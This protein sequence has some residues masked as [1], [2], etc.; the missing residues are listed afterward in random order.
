M[1]YQEIYDQ[2]AGYCNCMSEIDPC[3]VEKYLAQ[4]VDYV[5]MMT[6]WKRKSCET[7]LSSEREEV[8]APNYINDCG[9]DQGLTIIPLY[10]THIFEPT[11]Q[12]TIQLRDGVNFC[13]VL[14]DPEDYSFDTY[15]NELYINLS[16]Y[17][18]L[19]G[20][21]CDCTKFKQIIVRY[22]AGYDRIPDCILPIFCDLMSYII[23]L[24][25][26][27]CTQCT[28]CESGSM[29]DEEDFPKDEN[30]QLIYTW[31]Q[32]AVT[33]V[34]INQLGLMSLC[35]KKHDFLGVVV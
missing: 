33:T 27:G 21:Q 9:C 2:I 29:R 13:E 10:Y 16:K 20:G 28:D 7:F 14:V 23:E 5:S 6:C 8:F 35:G 32:Q 4:L 15:D 11:I 18:G 30:E 26:C 1:L 22:I 31:I 34:Y 19:A 17:L 3:N 24:N 12:V 25:A